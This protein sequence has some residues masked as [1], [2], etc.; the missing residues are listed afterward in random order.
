MGLFDAISDAIGPLDEYLKGPLPRGWKDSVRLRAVQEARN[1]LRAVA[2][3]ECSP[4]PMKTYVEEAKGRNHLKKVLTKS[5]H[6]A[7]LGLV[8][9]I[10]TEKCNAGKPRKDKDG[11]EFSAPVG[12][13]ITRI[14]EMT[15][16]ER[17]QNWPE[18]G[19]DQA[20]CMELSDGSIICAE[21]D[22]G[23][24][25]PGYLQYDGSLL[26]IRRSE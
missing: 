21:Q 1:I 23:G 20:I 24:T 15:E 17:E 2:I 6:T 14:R 5:E 18:M 16:K 25:G 7:W 22:A 26:L 3:L 4:H 12:L 8:A 10:Q 9:K 13:T 19:H 11:T